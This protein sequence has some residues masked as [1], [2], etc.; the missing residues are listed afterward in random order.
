VQVRQLAA[1]GLQISG[2]LLFGWRRRL[3]GGYKIVFGSIPGIVFNHALFS[4]GVGEDEKEFP[5]ILFDFRAHD[6]GPVEQVLGLASCDQLEHD[7]PF[8]FSF[9]DN[10]TRKDPK[11][12]TGPAISGRFFSSPEGTPGKRQLDLNN[13][14]TIIAY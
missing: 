5:G 10:K 3:F 11:R 1:G 6:S 12:F 4:V 14:C 9:P 2:M 13:L 7:S 8:L